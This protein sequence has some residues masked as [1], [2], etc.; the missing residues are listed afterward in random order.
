MTEDY[1]AG[2]K[3]LGLIAGALKPEGYSR[4]LESGEVIVTNGYITNGEE[5]CARTDFFAKGK[6]SALRQ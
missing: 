2:S 6:G 5:R 1:I 3:I 4:L